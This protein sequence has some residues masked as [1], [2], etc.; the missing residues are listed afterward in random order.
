[1]LAFSGSFP[2]VVVYNWFPGSLNVLS[3]I[4]VDDDSSLCCSHVTSVLFPEI[5]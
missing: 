2:L 1:M 5:F 3:V 4:F